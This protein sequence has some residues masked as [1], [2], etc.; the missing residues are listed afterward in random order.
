MKQTK[1]RE[2]AK[3]KIEKTFI[4]LIQFNNVDEIS[5]T[6]LVKIAKVNRSTF[7]TYY[8]DIFDLANQIKEKMFNNLLNLYNEEAIKKAHS[9]DFLKLFKH[10]KN[11]QI[12]YKTMFK[13][14]FDFMEYCN[15]PYSFDDAIK[16]LGTTT[17]LEYHIEFF[18]AG[19]SAIINKWL[20]NGCQETPEEMFE[21]IFR[22]YKGKNIIL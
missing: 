8:L 14:N 10:I 12:Y 19:V 17:N 16:Y 2:N 7:Y 4:N 3:E 21:I 6:K 13:L 22:E 5:V 20:M 18:K 15:S 9:Y 1:K 11:N